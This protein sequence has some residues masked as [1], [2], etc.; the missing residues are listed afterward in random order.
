MLKIIFGTSF[1]KISKKSSKNRFAERELLLIV[2][3]SKEMKTL[4]QTDDIL[5]VNVYEQL[6]NA[7]YGSLT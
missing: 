7:I 2:I 5:F 3:Y 6:K 4:E 1:S